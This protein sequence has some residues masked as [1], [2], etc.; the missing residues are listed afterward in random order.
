MPTA[1]E[2]PRPPASAQTTSADGRLR[3]GN[4]DGALGGP[5]AVEE[6]GDQACVGLGEPAVVVFG[7][8]F[9]EPGA[10]VDGVAVDDDLPPGGGGAALAV[11]EEFQ[12][13]DRLFEAAAGTAGGGER[14]GVGG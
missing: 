10:E 13:L 12:E 8:G 2:R 5:V 9:G 6:R 1:K 14:I 7:A 3:H 11:E 4:R